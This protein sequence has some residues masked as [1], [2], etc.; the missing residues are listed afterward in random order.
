V[1]SIQKSLYEKP[2]LLL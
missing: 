1:I 2:E